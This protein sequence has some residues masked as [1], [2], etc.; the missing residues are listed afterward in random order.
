MKAEVQESR[1]DEQ[2]GASSDL[3]TNLLKYTGGL[4]FSIILTGVSFWVSS[5]GAV[6]PG[7]VPVLLAALAIAQMGVHLLLF[8]HVTSGPEGTNNIMALAFG[9]FVVALVIFGSMIIMHS[10][11]ARMNDMPIDPHPTTMSP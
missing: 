3:R 2:P 1:H 10:L 9:V 11:D 8:L 7:G 5:T 4:V 6:W